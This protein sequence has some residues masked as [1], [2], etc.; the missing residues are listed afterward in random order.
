MIVRVFWTLFALEAAGLAILLLVLLLGKKPWG[1][2]GA[3]GAWIVVLPPLFLGALAAV[4]SYS[5]SDTVRISCTVLLAIPLIQMAL[6]PVHAGILRFRVN[7]SLA[8]DDDFRGQRRE[9]AHA[10]RAH[11]AARVRALIPQAGDLNG[12]GAEG[13]TLLRFALVNATQGP[14]SKE[15]AKAL[16]DA[17]ADPNVPAH[18]SNF[19]L[20]LAIL[21]GPEWTELL[22]QAG[23]NPNL[24]DGARRPLWWDA[25]TSDFDER[26]RTLE[27]FLRSG[28]DVHIRDGEGGPVAW[29]AYH[30][31]WRAA[32]MLVE[33]GAECRD[34]QAFGQPV[35]DILRDDLRNR[36]AYGHTVPPEMRKLLEKMTG[37]PAS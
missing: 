16:L 35:I 34:Q 22:L 28:A 25:V 32:W 24:P 4:F 13:E 15:V 14:E 1:P 21:E 11:D 10:I 20:T 19:P 8:G 2:E 7:R 17:G 30:K 27:I 37:E 3:V 33:R 9:L 5:Q 6:S 12:P 31:S 29:A 23:A 26:L 36:E 18:S